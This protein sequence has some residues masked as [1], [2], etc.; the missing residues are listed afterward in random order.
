MTKFNTPS[1]MVPLDSQEIRTRTKL[2]NQ[3]R[4]GVQSPATRRRRAHYWTLLAVLTIFVIPTAVSAATWVGSSWSSANW[5]DTAN[6]ELWQPP[7]SVSGNQVIFAEVVLPGLRSASRV[8]DQFDVS[9]MSFRGAIGV[10]QSFVVN[11]SNDGL[12]N[13]T[14]RDGINLFG[15]VTENHSANQ[16]VNAAIKLSAPTVQFSTGA[17][18]GT[19]VIGGQ[20][21]TNGNELRL[22][23]GNNG[24]G[25]DGNI[26][27]DGAITGSGSVTVTS[28][29]DW[30]NGT[31]RMTARNSYSGPTTIT[32]H[33]LLKMEGNGRLPDPSDVIV[34]HGGRLEM[35]GM[36]DA[37]N[38]LF[39]D[40]TVALRDNAALVIGN[41]SNSEGIGSFTG[42]I[43]GQGSLVKRGTGTFT[44]LG[45]NSY[46]G[47][48]L[49]EKGVL[50]V[51]NSSG[52]GTGSGGVVV[53][54]NGTLG[55]SGI[56]SD[57]VSVESGGILSPGSDIGKLT[58]GSATFATDSTL[59]IDLAGISQGVEYDVLDVNDAA[60]LSGSLSVSLADGFSLGA[61]QQFD[62]M[63]IGGNRTGTF[64]GLDEG[65]RVANF[66]QDLFIT[67]KGGDGNDVSLFT[68][69]GLLGDFN[70]NG[71]LDAADI[72]Q[73]SM[74]VRT[75]TNASEFD[76]NR[77][78]RVEGQ[79]REVWVHDV[80]KTYFGDANLDGV[81]SSSDFVR[82]FAS[83]KFES[84]SAASWS[85]GDW[86]GD[87]KFT[88]S[89]FVAAFADGGFEQGPRAAV[90]AVPE[91]TSVLLIMAGLV[92][93]TVA[94]R[95]NK[96]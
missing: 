51:N 38:G 55:G 46:T 28:S 37:I 17:T 61:G 70:G 81:F 16:T 48:T 6:W 20:V 59:S 58:V 12:I 22:I 92:P 68:R 87:G 1:I 41:G 76:L 82:V 29:N 94:R 56:I 10:D 45:A 40:G 72:D 7:T 73:L 34:E 50:L 31:V 25:N 27:L 67:Y 3:F 79:D 89:D 14:T 23:E 95:R 30:R 47:R 19:L 44:V 80:A 60:N 18:S 65:A 84:N 64:S 88:S 21:D 49:V 5:T 83:G 96:V 63:S 33:G 32:R 78:G 8:D 9:W 57:H 71:I 35:H 11:G 66:G 2:G 90:R 85:Q 86:N 13:L 77:D 39:G 24:R 26:R 4:T 75:G 69:G 43:Q 91:P 62:I 54:A 42:Q 53:K 52:D 36:T 93:F 74:Q 15:S